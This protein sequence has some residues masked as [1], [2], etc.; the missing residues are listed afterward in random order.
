MADFSVCMHYD[1]GMPA[2]L[3]HIVRHLETAIR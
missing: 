3:D 1:V 2:T